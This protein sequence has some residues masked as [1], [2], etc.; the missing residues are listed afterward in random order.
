M[1][2][3]AIYAGSFDPFT[4]GHTSIIEK[5]LKFID[6]L[7]IVIGTNSSKKNFLSVK[8][9]A[10]SIRFFSTRK[11]FGLRLKVV[12]IEEEYIVKY[13][14]KNNIKL[15]IRGVRN[16]DDYNYERSIY[17]INQ[18]INPEVETIYLLPDNDKSMISSSTV[19]SLIGYRH[20]I[21]EI[22]KFLPTGSYEII[23]RNKIRKHMVNGADILH[24]IPEIRFQQILFLY[25]V[26]NRYFHNLAHILY[27]LEE[28][29]LIFNKGFYGLDSKMPVDLQKRGDLHKILMI[30]YFFHDCVYNTLSE[31]GENEIMSAQHQ[32][33]CFEERIKI[34][35]NT[36]YYD[37]V[38][39]LILATDLSKKLPKDDFAHK[40][41][42]DIDIIPWGKT[43]S[44]DNLLL[45]DMIRKEYIGVDPTV[46]QKVKYK[47]GRIE[48]LEKM[49][50]RKQ[51]YYYLTL[52]EADLRKNIELEIEH[53][54]NNF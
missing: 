11:L 27:G 8:E 23:L 37:T 10:D 39:S 4:I 30:A 17:D 31:S 21:Y 20:W 24:W 40:L 33:K 36:T 18:K 49:L 42:R 35:G 13:A 46:K 45:C 3:E 53:L 7:H 12:H 2:I 6:V 50:K 22:N 29:E 38:H 32:L 43:H 34:E 25:S 5:A 19:K 9:R 26:P 44:T 41:M 1:K 48:F 14:Q 28:I 52:F 15:L 51:I 47:K 54:K 16:T